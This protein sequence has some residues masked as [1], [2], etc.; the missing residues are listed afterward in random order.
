MIRSMTGFGSA[1]IH[2]DE[3]T[4]R[5]ECRSVN[6]KELQLTFR[7]PD[8]FRLKEIELRRLV[9]A[10]IRRGHA[11]VVL[12]CR[13]RVGQAEN[14]VNEKAVREYVEMLKG[15]AEAADVPFQADLAS[16]MRAP[17]VLKDV[18]TDEDLRDQ[19]W[20]DVLAGCE[21]ALDGLLEM[22]V[23]EGGNL[24]GQLRE[25]CDGMTARIDAI[26]GGL[27]DAVAEYRDRLRE[28]LKR[29]L[30]G[31]DTPVSE[32]ALARETA[33]YAERSDV[34]EEIERL[35]SHLAQMAEA[36]DGSDEPVGRKME[37]LGQEMLREANTMAAK[38]PAGDQV[39]EVL[40][41][42]GDVERLREQAR[43]VE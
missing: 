27:G 25:L 20:P 40:E 37:F 9:E 7:M 30:E 42:K 35:R 26:A 34:S 2:C 11:Y 28:R 41:L 32:D 18:T 13:P 19:L 29:L 38:I 17:G 10:R 14:M 21:Q 6:H 16:L 15:V 12:T 36:L 33:Y 4:V 43:N 1:E 31:V 23:T 5:V 3:W 24:A 22:R 8:A 39:A